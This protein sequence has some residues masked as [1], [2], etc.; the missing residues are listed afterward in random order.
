MFVVILSHFMKLQIYHGCS[1]R[2]TVRIYPFFLFPFWEL[3]LRSISTIKLFSHRT[4]LCFG[5]IRIK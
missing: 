4:F 5:G 1:L 3:N 2:C